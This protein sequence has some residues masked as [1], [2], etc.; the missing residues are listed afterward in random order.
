MFTSQ[1]RLRAADPVAAAAAA[2]SSQLIM[3]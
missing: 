1:R 3:P 2:R